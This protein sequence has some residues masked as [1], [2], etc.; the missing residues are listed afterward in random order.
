MTNIS[1]LISSSENNK[2]YF[3]DS[4][5][6]DYI[7]EVSYYFNIID[8]VFS[9]SG[10]I[11]N[12]FMIFVLLLLKGSLKTHL[13]FV[14]SLAISDLL[15]ALLL[16]ASLFYHF[17]I[18]LKPFI[19][20]TAPSFLSKTFLS[21]YLMAQY[22]GLGT[23][24]AISVDILIKIRKPLRY[25]FLMSKRRGN[26]I[27]ICLWFVTPA[28][29]ILISF[30]LLAFMLNQ[31]VDPLAVLIGASV[32]FFALC[33]LFFVVFIILYIVII[34][35][36]RNFANKYSFRRR[37]SIKKAAV[38]FL[39]VLLT[40]FICLLPIVWLLIPFLISKDSYPYL[41][42][43]IVSSLYIV[44]TIC[45]PIIYTLRIPEIK[46]KYWTI[47]RKMYHRGHSESAVFNLAN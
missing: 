3:N 23:M 34:C 35:S 43:R 22:A 2:S 38:T 28:A 20:Q 47:Y 1:E 42:V 14:L 21:L 41:S 40:Y 13:K 30:C 9:L 27:I 29:F 7:Y 8:I 16:F 46:E 18:G 33:V 11:L 4:D 31:R 10:V 12:I 45:D 39:F 25:K 44:N 36:I 37:T 32:L 6:N 26:I 5:Y 15:I 17:P 19:I 24:L